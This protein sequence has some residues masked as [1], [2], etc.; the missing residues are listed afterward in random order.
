MSDNRRIAE[1]YLDVENSKYT[2][3]DGNAPPTKLVLFKGT[4][5]VIRCHLRRGDRT[6]AFVP[7]EDAQWLFAIDTSYLPGHEDPIRSVQ[8]VFNIGDDWTDRNLA[9]GEISWSINTQ[10]TQL[11]ELM[12]SQASI[13][14]TAELWMLPAGGLPILMCQWTVD[15]RN[16]VTEV[17]ATT[18]LVYATSLR[19]DGDDI[20]LC[21]AD[22]SVAQRWTKMSAAPRVPKAIKRRKSNA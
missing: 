16:V 7:P 12:G 18:D 21:F 20:V 19:Y 15:I 11:A 2:D 5:I 3:S 8:A 10:S 1:I 17:S 6:T 14:G 4:E 13:T 22:G 9:E